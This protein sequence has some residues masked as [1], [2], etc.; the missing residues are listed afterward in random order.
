[1][2]MEKASGVV[3][4]L[5]LRLLGPLAV[6]KN[7]VELALPA[8][9]KVRALLVFLAMTPGSA[10]RARLC[11]LLWDVPND[12]RGE[13][14]WSLTKLRS[15]LDDA[16]HRRVE[17]PGDAVALNLS[18]CL[19]D[20]LEVARKLE[21]GVET[22]DLQQ[23]RAVEQ[24]FA[25]EFAEGLEIDRNPQFASWL[26]AQRRRFRAAH[27]TVLARLVGRL[28]EQ[29]SFVYLEKW[30][31]IAPFDTRAH[32]S[33]LSALWCAGRIQESEQHFATT[34]RLFEAEGLEWLTLREAWKAIRERPQHARATV[35]VSS[36]TKTLTE[37]GAAQPIASEGTR[38]SSIC[39]MP[40][41]D[42][43]SQAAA[44]GG[45]ADGL[46]ED[47]IT[48]LAK[49]R[50]LFVIARGSVFALGDRNIPA[51]EAARLLN[52]DYV[53]SGSVRRHAGRISVT[54]E[55][56]EARSARILWA[57]DFSYQLD[58]ALAVLDEIG[59][60]IVACIAEEIEMAERNRAILKPPSSLNAWEAYHRGLWH[61]YR[62]NGED[63][64]RAA[65][66]FQMALRQDPTYARAHAGLSFT[67]FQNAFLHRP[68][69]RAAAIEQAYA[70]ACESLVADDRDP[71]AH[72]AMGR[73]LWLRGCQDESLR[74]LQQSVSLSPNFA[75]GHYTLGFVHGQSG[76]ARLAIAS[77]DHSL[78][79]SPFDPLMFAMFAA[80][81][82]ALFRLGQYQE[83]ASWAVKGA[84]RPN[85][86]VHILAIAANCLSAAG[87]LDEARALVM[88]L[89]KRVEGYG[90]DDFLSAFHFAPETIALFRLNSKRIGLDG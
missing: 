56:A 14:R 79:L 30:L 38:R 19:V 1:M 78:R 86:H 37:I 48:R 33:M 82:L 2:N 88:S 80:R 10:T 73:A 85:A 90:L 42:R 5:R 87:Q 50:S 46:T 32:E 67:H 25:G 57:N 31:Q 7:E 3:S 58:D 17:T 62:F 18:D 8:S 52:V 72:W 29:E 6:F 89:R 26:G 23:L 22:L 4:T 68:A 45:L 39:V 21:P 54:V 35:S 12:P 15:V 20:V 40:F 74:E 43:T 63:N 84:A 66:F 51:V 77:T 70:A 28:T 59:N 61:V 27:V 65:H 69:E 34:I 36:S 47:I 60:T 76:D 83:A 13:L 75:L 55:V 44:R 11:E 71:A 49:L 24:L 53:A 16:A 64:E 9:R 41:V 81:S